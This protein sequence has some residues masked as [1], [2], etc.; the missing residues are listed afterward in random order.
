MKTRICLI[1]LLLATL[2]TAQDIAGKWHGSLSIGGTDLPL[3]F[4]ISK[5]ATGYTATMDSPSQNATGIPVQTVTFEG[6]SLTLAIPAG[7]IEYKGTLTDGIVKGSFTQNGNTFPLHLTRDAAKK[8]KATRQQEPA[9][10]YPYHTEDVT[11][12]GVSGV[13]LAGTLTLPK[14][15]GSFPAVILVNGSG[16]QNRDSEILGHKPFLVLADYLTKSG[17]AVLR[18]DD[19]GIAGSTGDF[20][21]ATTNDFATDAEAAF[22]YLKSRK[23]I[24]KNKIGIIGHSEGGAIAPIVAARNK[25]VAFIVMMA[26]PGIAGDEQMLL[27]NYLLGKA[28]GMPEEE[29]SKLGAINRK[30]YNVIKEES[31]T[32]AMK[33]RLSEIFN[34]DMR[35]LFISNGLPAAEVDQYISAQVNEL[36]SPWYSNFI[37]YDPAPALEA[38]KCPILALNGDK[39]LQVAPMANLEGIKRAAEKS[40]N[41]KVTIK[42]YPGLNHLLQESA[43]GSPAEYGSIEQTLSPAV[44]A[45]IQAWIAKQI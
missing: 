41:K 44:M 1:A 43:T 24:N 42:H 21:T 23:E 20:G 29:L 14:K 19:R 16:P 4:N 12:P 17:I 22:N 31:T 13:T 30:I 37:K 45:D 40:G 38:V 32:D 27:Q 18:Y 10:P 25:D 3:V 28:N 33:P 11:I 36:A 35:P 26:G 6:T 34:K 15:D 2:A 8:I 9:K 7:G 39:D 5:A